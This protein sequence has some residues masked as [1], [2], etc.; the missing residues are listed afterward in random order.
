[1]EE[2]K[3]FK[4]SEGWIRNFKQR[5]KISRRKV[6]SKTKIFATDI[7]PKVLAFFK[8]INEMKRT[9][10]MTIFINLD[11]TGIFFEMT[12]DYTLDLSSLKKTRIRTCSLEKERCTVIPIVASDGYVFPPIIIYKT[13][14]KYHQDTDDYIKTKLHRTMVNKLNQLDAIVSANKKAWNNSKVMIKLIIPFIKKTINARY[15]ERAKD[16]VLVMDNCSPHVNDHTINK[17]V[18]ES[19]FN[20][21]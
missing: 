12:G 9:N 4:A 18:R 1:M 13:H 10:P 3:K 2:L 20:M 11:E 7:Q 17:L 16:I 19:I 5:F 15:K 6:N 8:E 21:L 14:S